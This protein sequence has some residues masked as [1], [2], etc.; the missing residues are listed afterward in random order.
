MNISFGFLS[1]SIS[2]ILYVLLL[3]LQER[4]TENRK[5]IAHK[6]LSKIKSN[7]FC[8]ILLLVSMSNVCQTFEDDMETIGT[9]LTNVEVDSERGLKQ[10]KGF[11][12]HLGMF[13]KILMF[14]SI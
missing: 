11:L 14:E 8:C 1:Q 4:F 2:S 6:I 10:Q 12:A 5:K 3:Y 13:V 9:M 7:D